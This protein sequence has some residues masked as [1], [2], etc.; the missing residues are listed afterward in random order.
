MCET[1][2]VHIPNEIIKFSKRSKAWT[3]LLVQIKKKFK[4]PLQTQN[5]CIVLSVV[6]TTFY[7]EYN[8]IL[9]MEGK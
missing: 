6:D 1:R 9:A 8:I 3:P 2:R 5:S 4:N 7:H